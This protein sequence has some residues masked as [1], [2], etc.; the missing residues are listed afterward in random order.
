M[1]KQ[2]SAD[3]LHFEHTHRPLPWSCFNTADHNFIKLWRISC[4]QLG[5]NS[6]A[7]GIHTN[8]SGWNINPTQKFLLLHLYLLKILHPQ[9]ALLFIY[10]LVIIRYFPIM[11][12][13]FLV[14]DILS[15]NNE[16]FLS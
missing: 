8:T 9:K 10:F 12:T 15:H 14:F 2:L 13:S 1:V 11:L 7:F 4:I 5:L 16:I 3:I 6:C